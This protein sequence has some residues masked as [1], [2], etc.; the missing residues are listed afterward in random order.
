LTSSPDGTVLPRSLSKSQ[1]E[2]AASNFDT[3][4]VEDEEVLASKFST[5]K[6]KRFTPKDDADELGQDDSWDSDTIGRHREAY[7]PR[8]SRRRSNAASIHEALAEDEPDTEVIF[9]E[10]ESDL[11]P[12][13]GEVATSRKTKRAAKNTKPLS[14]AQDT[15]QPKKRGRK[16][17]QPVSEEMV[18][19]EEVVEQVS[20]IAEFKE[21]SP[22]PE[23][24]I[25]AKIPKKKRG[26]PRKSETAK[27]EDTINKP[28]DAE[29]I[30]TSD[31]LMNPAPPAKKI[32]AHN[33]T[34][35]VED[36]AKRLTKQTSSESENAETER[37][38][39]DDK[40]RSISPLKEVDRNSILTSQ[41]TISDSDKPTAAS[42]KKPALSQAGKSLYRVGLSKN[43][44]IA[45]L[46]KF[47]KK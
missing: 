7:K 13:Y 5:K 39:A 16:K 2:A 41:S 26:R 9:E 15:A 34:A 36:T 47:L 33:N 19:D 6:K 24:D 40:T 10:P 23:T 37:E 44:R 42:I 8:I 22:A 20:N 32:L 21:P 14:A 17:K 4:G 25:P 38:E 1:K 35:T 31:T 46:L 3:F 45:P 18:L 43:S 28:T 12:E 27:T 11:D 30:S 29:T